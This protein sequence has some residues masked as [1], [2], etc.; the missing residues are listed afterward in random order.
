[1]NE[2]K[3]GYTVIFVMLGLL[4]V[5]CF[6]TLQTVPTPRPV[7]DVQT[8]YGYTW[9]LLLFALPTFALWIWAHLRH[10]DKV[11][12][13]AL[14]T[15]IGIFAPIGFALD[16]FL[17]LLFFKFPNTG[18]TLG[19]RLPGFDWETQQWGLYIPLEEFGF[20]GFGI[21]F[22]V[23]FYL[24][25][26]GYFLRLYSNTEHKNCE[27]G[28]VRIHWLSIF[29]ALALIVAAIL[30][31]KLGPDAGQPG[32]PGWAIFEIL[33]AFLPAALLYRTVRDFVNWRAFGFAAFV[34]LLISII[35]EVTLGLPYQWWAF[36]DEQMLGLFVNAWTRVPIEEPFLW[37]MVS[38]TTI[39]F[40][41]AAKLCFHIREH[42]STTIKETLF[43]PKATG[44]SE[45][46]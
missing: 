44:D 27:H 33:V 46:G 26:D 34:T 2:P 31:K 10:H 5:A 15:T 30:F 9:S 8:P 45:P 28:I 19:I 40:F 12:K 4:A 11:P 18:A 13:K 1:M 37:I 43:R 17:G 3:R 21:A 6:V 39:I 22:V 25:L 24:W 29:T 20:Y 16:T 32:F 7:H 35:W 42:Q 14:W 36:R 38:F 41:E 23:S